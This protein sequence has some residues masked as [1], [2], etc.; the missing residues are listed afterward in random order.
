VEQLQKKDIIKPP[1]WRKIRGKNIGNSLQPA[2]NP[3]YTGNSEK[4][5]FD[6]FV[7]TVSTAACHARGLV[8]TPSRKLSATP[9]GL[10]STRPVVRKL[11]LKTYN[12][13][14]IS[15]ATIPPALGGSTTTSPPIVIV[16]L[17]QQLDCVIVDYAAPTMPHPIKAKFSSSKSRFLFTFYRTR[18]SGAPP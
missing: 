7:F 2:S 4:K 13:V 14:D 9:G 8:V 3:N 12:F 18:H 6:Y 10:T 15:N 5:Y 1:A 17:R 16:V 11:T